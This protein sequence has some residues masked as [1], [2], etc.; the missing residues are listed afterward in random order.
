MKERK[1]ASYNDKLI[2]SLATR[3]QLFIFWKSFDGEVIKA[4]E[5]EK[6]IDE[7]EKFEIQNKRAIKKRAKTVKR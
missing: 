2:D 4:E 7:I 3:I 1:M 5:I 6:Y